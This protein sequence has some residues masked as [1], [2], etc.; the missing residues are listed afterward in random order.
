ME[1]KNIEPK[2]EYLLYFEIVIELD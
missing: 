1:I 2:F